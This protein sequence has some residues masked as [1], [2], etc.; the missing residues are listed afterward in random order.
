[1]LLKYFK[2]TKILQFL[3]QVLYFALK[4]YWKNL[5]TWGSLEDEGKEKLVHDSPDPVQLTHNSASHSLLY[6]NSVQ[7]PYSS[8]LFWV[9]LGFFPRK[10]NLSSTIPFHDTG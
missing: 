2:V 7:P 4:N 6:S 5:W 1:M 10:I 3:K 8:F 9:V